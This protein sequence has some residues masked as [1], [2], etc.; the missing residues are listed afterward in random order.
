MLPIH[1]EKKLFNKE[2]LLAFID[3]GIFSFSSNGIG[4]EPKPFSQIIKTSQQLSEEIRILDLELFHN[5]YNMG[6]E[7][8]K[9]SWEAKVINPSRKNQK[10]P[11][12]KDYSDFEVTNEK[13]KEF[14]KEWKKAKDEL[15]SN[16]NLPQEFLQFGT[17][18]VEVM[19]ENFLSN[20]EENGFLEA[21]SKFIEI[22]ST[23]EKLLKKPV[24]ALIEKSNFKSKVKICLLELELEEDLVE[25]LA[26]KISLEDCFGNWLCKQVEIQIRK[27]GDSKASNQ[28]DI[29]HISHLPYVNFF[30]TDKRIVEMTKQVLRF[31][32]L[33]QSLKIDKLP[34]SISNSIKEL[35]NTLF[36]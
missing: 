33:P 16:P 7:G 10:V 8:H 9:H 35:E 2:I 32:D 20:A 26:D 24:E 6:Y 29:E 18:F 34:I 36:K 14:R 19:L 27:S 13:S 17:N 11:R 22:D 12:L 28:A 25:A 31:K 3:K 5:L 15:V 21:F 23:D 1:I 4:L 30:F